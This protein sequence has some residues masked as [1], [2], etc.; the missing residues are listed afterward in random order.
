MI[1]LL[2]YPEQNWPSAGNESE[3]WASIMAQD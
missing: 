2:E 3:C 1:Y